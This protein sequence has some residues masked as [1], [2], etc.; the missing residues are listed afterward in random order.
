M[1]RGQ[2]VDIVS[3]RPAEEEKAA[4]ARARK[5]RTEQKDREQAAFL[6]I[7]QSEGGR[8]V[9]SLVLKRLEKRIDQLVA[10][11]AEAKT[12][13]SVLQDLGYMES[14]ARKAINALHERH[15]KQKTP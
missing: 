6:G 15:V 10:A 12:L 3:G 8:Q 2:P 1:D 9:I 14:V 4:D 7:T 11:D 5:A 13:V